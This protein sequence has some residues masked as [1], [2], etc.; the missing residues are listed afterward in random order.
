MIPAG[1][2]L[3]IPEYSSGCVCD[4]SM[5]TSV[6]YLSNMDMQTAIYS[7]K[8]KPVKKV[9]KHT[10]L[11]SRGV[12]RISITIN[13]VLPSDKLHCQIIDAAGRTLFQER[14]VAGKNKHTFTWDYYTLSTGIYFISM[15]TPTSKL[16]RKMLVVK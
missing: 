16:V 11:L 3:N 8:K 5:Q 7:T 2:L 14:A 6:A 15:K 13:N 12:H 1:G 4:Y 10:L 9:P